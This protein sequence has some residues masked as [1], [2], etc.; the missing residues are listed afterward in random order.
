MFKGGVPNMQ[1][2][3]KQLQKM[4]EKMAKVQEELANE[5]VEHSTG[6]GNDLRVLNATRH[7]STG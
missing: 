6:G 4:Q 5:R 3:M 2:M 1:G 7:V